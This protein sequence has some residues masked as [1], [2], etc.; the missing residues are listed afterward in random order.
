MRATEVSVADVY[1]GDVLAAT[2]SRTP[3]GTVF[4]YRDAYDGPALACHLPLGPPIQVQG[5]NLPPFF[6]NLLPEGHRLAALVARTRTSASDMFSLLLEAGPDTIGDVFATPN[7]GSPSYY[8][9]GAIRSLGDLS[10]EE[11]IAHAAASGK[12]GVIPGVQDKVS[13]SD[14]M[15]TVPV[16]TGAIGSAILKV[17]PKAYPLLVENEYCSLGIAQK[18]GFRVAKASIVRDRDGVTGLLVRRFDRVKEGRKLTRLPQEDGC[19]IT[20][21]YPADKYRVSIADIAKSFQAFASAPIPETLELIRR[22][23]FS[24][25][26]GNADM[27]AKNI[28][29]H[30]VAESGIFA[31]TPL[32]DVTCTALYP[33]LES[34][35][36]L[37]LDGRDDNLRVS[38]FEEFGMR[39][40]VR[41]LATH[42]ALQALV[43]KLEAHANPLFDL[44]FPA[45]DVARAKALLRQR[46]DNFMR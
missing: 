28:S 26:I 34:R 10:F 37:M 42:N 46:L 24:Y 11:L 21:R 33:A 5:D 40:G 13:L 9:A 6:A 43:T 41:K 17:A 31:Q 36:A 3:H 29:L 8:A 25:L 44:S 30:R 2:L 22:Y 39:F 12:D 45:E 35:Q 32:Y 18:C 4:A 20:D 1:K 16:H 23:A 14:A 27:H 7:G 19:Q 38:H 15:I